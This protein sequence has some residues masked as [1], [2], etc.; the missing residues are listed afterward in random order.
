[1][2]V[3]NQEIKITPTPLDCQSRDAVDDRRMGA[4]AVIGRDRLYKPG[5]TE[6]FLFSDWAKFQEMAGSL[7]WRTTY[8][9]RRPSWSF[10]GGARSGNETALETI[11]AEMTEELALQNE[12]KP[13]E[14]LGT[15]IMQAFPFIA[16]QI[17]KFYSTAID[18]AAV[19]S[20]HIPFDALPRETQVEIEQIVAGEVRRVKA[21]WFELSKIHELFEA[22]VSGAA[23]LGDPE[24]IL[25]PHSLVAAQIWWLTRMGENVV[26]VIQAY[27][28]Q[29]YQT[30]VHRQQYLPDRF[31]YDDRF[32]AIEGIPESRL[33]LNNGF[34]DHEGQIHLD[35]L[36]EGQRNYL[37]PST[38]SD[39]R[40]PRQ[41]S[42]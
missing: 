10:P 24:D 41:H 21:C 1:M 31:L 30:I 15:I 18:V 36:P 22:F 34:F 5:I 37:V 17:N 4:V 16:A 2:S 3:T 32:V 14:I 35:E 25:R 19:T 27:N 8:T 11:A 33:A 20:M 28:R 12:L 26:P 38:R 42:A 39:Q 13:D 7:K 6:V 40:L 23:K 29:A 9:H